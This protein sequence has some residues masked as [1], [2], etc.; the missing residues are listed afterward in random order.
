MIKESS[1]V[2]LNE[3][4]LEIQVC[5]VLSK[6]SSMHTFSII[7]TYRQMVQTPAGVPTSGPYF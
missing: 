3:Q 2:S 4:V 5:T 6:Y 7:L 1:P